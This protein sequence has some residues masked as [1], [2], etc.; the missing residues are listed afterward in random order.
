MSP[1]VT[2]DAISNIIAAVIGGLIGLTPYMITVLRERRGKDTQH[3][4]FVYAKIYHL[5]RKS[6]TSRPVYTR[7]IQRLKSN[8]AIYDEM[9]FFRLNIFD[10]EQ[11]DFT[12]VDRS[13]G[14]VDLQLLYPW[15]KP[16]FS[17][18]GAA[19]VPN[20]LTHTIK[21]KS[22]TFFTRSMYF[23]GFQEGNTDVAMKMEADT[24]EARMII[25]FSSIPEFDTIFKG[26]PRAYRRTSGMEGS[27]DINEVHPGIYVVSHNDLQKEDVILVVFDVDWDIVEQ[28]AQAATV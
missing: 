5:T 24:R 1:E 18:R 6:D 17:D 12:T 7:F 28:K 21:K 14:V 16:Q 4:K 9:H 10:E 2:F 25:D 23:N 19:K 22:H 3:Y 8:I 27:I 26:P 15:Q 20:M 11:N 13:S